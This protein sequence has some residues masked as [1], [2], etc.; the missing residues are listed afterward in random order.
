M[1]LTLAPLQPL[2]LPSPCERG[3]AQRRL[4]CTR[5]NACLELAAGAEWPAMTCSNCAAYKPPDDEQRARDV[6]G[7]LLIAMAIETDDEDEA[8]AL[9]DGRRR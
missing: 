5:A 2:P 9:L 3:Q 8:S 1:A 4:D 7:L 6:A